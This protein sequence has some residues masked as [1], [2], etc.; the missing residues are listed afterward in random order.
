M[1]VCLSAF[2]SLS[3]SISKSFYVMTQGAYIRPKSGL[4]FSRTSDE[5]RKQNFFPL[6]SVRSGTSYAPSGTYYL[7]NL[8]ADDFVLPFKILYVLCSEGSG[9]RTGQPSKGHD[10]QT[11]ERTNG[12]T[13]R[14]C[15]QD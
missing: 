14:S 1:L 3:L 11:Y 9:R 2:L 15:G 13:G 12:R 5:S 4:R 8:R 7:P 6:S 10:E